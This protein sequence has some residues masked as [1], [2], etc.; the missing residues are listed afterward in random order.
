MNKNRVRRL[1]EIICPACSYIFADEDYEELITYWGD[2]EERVAYCPCC[3]AYLVY[4]EF[5]TRTFEV[6]VMEGE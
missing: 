2:P 4:R 3:E 6:K 5:V 1:M